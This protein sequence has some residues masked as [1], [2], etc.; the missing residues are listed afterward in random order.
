M[1]IVYKLDQAAG[2]VRT[3]V[4]GPITVE[5]ILNHLKNTIREKVLPLA[6]LVDAREA[7]PPFLSPNDMR[8]LAER[9][10]AM[11]FD[12]QALGPR[13]VVVEDLTMFGL[14]RIFATFVST[15]FTINVFR[16]SQDA[17]AWLIEQ[18]GAR[19]P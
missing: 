14:V 9:I 16:R 7:S 4:T 17:E 6:E 18:T 15:V 3:T 1:P 11:T 19:R 8:L 5:D 13:A 12:R 2:L 10:L